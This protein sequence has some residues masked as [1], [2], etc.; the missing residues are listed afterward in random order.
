MSWHLV[1]LKGKTK[2]SNTANETPQAF[3]THIHSS[4]PTLNLPHSSST[5]F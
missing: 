4:L 1:S 2:A 5:V 3:L